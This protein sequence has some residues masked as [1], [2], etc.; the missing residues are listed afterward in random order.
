MG[1]CSDS[2]SASIMANSVSSERGSCWNMADMGLEGSGPRRLWV[3]TSLKDGSEDPGR[4]GLRILRETGEG[5]M[6]DLAWSRAI[7]LVRLSISHD[8]VLRIP[9][10]L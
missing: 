6:P 5:A 4:A 9:D 2:P 10:M 3:R 8:A 7:T 1:S